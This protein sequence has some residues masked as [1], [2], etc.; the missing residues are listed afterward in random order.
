MVRKGGW[1]A[2]ALGGLR[3]GL[4]SPQREC[5]CAE[6]QAQGETLWCDWKVSRA[7]GQG[8]CKGSKSFPQW[9]INWKYIRNLELCC[10][11]CCLF[12]RGNCSWS[13]FYNI[14]I[15]SLATSGTNC[16][17]CACRRRG[18]HVLMFKVIL[19]MG[20]LTRGSDSEHV[21]LRCLLSDGNSHIEPSLGCT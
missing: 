2:A 12:F 13:F 11:C 19:R 8:G 4:I 14:F 17:I 20:N 3:T 9:I 1:Q 10:C 21:E 7:P 16:S 15:H 18:D 6:L 5:T